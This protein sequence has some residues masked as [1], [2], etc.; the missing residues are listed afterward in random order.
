MV[1]GLICNVKRLGIYVCV[2]VVED[3]EYH[4]FPISNF[5]QIF[6]YIKEGT[7]LEVRT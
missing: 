6:I 4:M 5:D 1:V 7:V 3:R 2:E